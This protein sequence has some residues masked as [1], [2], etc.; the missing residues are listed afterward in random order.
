MK[1]LT[2]NIYEKE[3]YIHKMY[4]EELQEELQR[5]NKEGIICIVEGKKDKNALEKLGVENIKVLDKPLFEIVEELVDELVGD[6]VMVAIL[7]DLD[8]KGKQLYSRLYTDLQ[9]H[10]IKVDNRLR[11]LLFKAHISHI[12]GLATYLST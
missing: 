12:E 8:D 2:K 6:L 1:L 4:E 9:R 5:I 10:H 3:T 7:T 11:K